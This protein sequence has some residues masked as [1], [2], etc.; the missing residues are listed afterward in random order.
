M[1]FFKDVH[2]LNRMGREM[3]ANMPSP[4]EQMAA[5]QAR[6]AQVT[7][8]MNEQSEAARAVAAD[9]V[10]GVAAVVS[11][12]QAG[13]VVNFDPTVQLQLLVTAGPFPPHLATVSTVVPQIH[14][15]RTQPG[16]V[17]PVD[18]S[19]SDPRHVLVTWNRAV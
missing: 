1:G 12:V 19:R 13:P 14:L 18:V 10:A 11:A 17:L 5:A 16:T 9:G 8:S 15:A 7:A 4:A 2:G 3:Q 6:M